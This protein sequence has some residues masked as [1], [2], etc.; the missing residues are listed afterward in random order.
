MQVW[1][2]VFFCCHQFWTNSAYWLVQVNGLTLLIRFEILPHPCCG[3][4][5]CN[6]LFSSRCSARGSL[7]SLCVCARL[8]WGVCVCV[9]NAS[10]PPPRDWMTDESSF[11]Y[12]TNTPTCWDRAQSEP[13]CH[14][15][16]LEACTWQY[17]EAGKII[18]LILI[19][20]A[21]KW[22]IDYQPRPTWDNRHA[23]CV[24]W[25]TTWI[26]L[27]TEFSHHL[28]QQILFFFPSLQR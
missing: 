18:E 12:G 9:A 6:H 11:G 15:A 19:Y 26:L 10:G 5:L 22:F 20:R 28:S 1:G 7:A 23:V 13:S 17:I 25:R 16:C 24:M 27:L 2:V 21:I 3:I 4:W 8:C 14:P